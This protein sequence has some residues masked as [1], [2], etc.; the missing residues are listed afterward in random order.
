MHPKGLNAKRRGYPM[1]IRLFMLPAPNGGRC[2]TRLLWNRTA[3]R[4]KCHSLGRPSTQKPELTNQTI[5]SANNWFYLDK[6]LLGCG[7]DRICSQ[8]LVRTR[9]RSGIG[10]DIRDW[11]QGCV[12]RASLCTSLNLKCQRR[13][14]VAFSAQV[15]HFCGALRKPVPPSP[16][17]ILKG[18]T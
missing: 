13:A 1:T 8:G 16:I 4:S 9:S 5:S 12:P 17:P 7:Q 10:Q 11:A 14:A 15:P 2:A 6:A 18:G 3:L